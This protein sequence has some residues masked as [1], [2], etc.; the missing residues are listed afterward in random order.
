MFSEGRDAWHCMRDFIRWYWKVALINIETLNYEVISFL[1]SFSLF[2]DFNEEVLKFVSCKY[3]I[4][5]CH[6]F[7]LIF[8]VQFHEKVSAQS[9]TTT[10]DT[11][12]FPHLGT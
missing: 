1:L 6:G 3:V 5:T 2:D 4:N 9:P 10:N 7:T 12:D 8:L 11:V